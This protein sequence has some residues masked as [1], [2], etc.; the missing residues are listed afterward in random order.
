MQALGPKQI[1]L[2]GALT[3]WLLSRYAFS[4]PGVVLTSH[5]LAAAVVECWAHHLASQGIHNLWLYNLGG[6]AEF[7]TLAV[8]LSIF[9]GQRWRWWILGGG[10]ALYVLVQIIERVK[11][12]SPDEFLNLSAI[13]GAAL[14][15]SASAFLLYKLANDELIALGSRP[16][17]LLFSSMALY[18]GG[19]IPLMGLLGVMTDRNEEL[20]DRIYAINDVLF[21]ASNALIIFA[22]IRFRIRGATLWPMRTL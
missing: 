1:I 11:A 10:L 4:W 16:E 12:T 6:V 7:V 2:L 17:F 8:F 14:L 3:C 19:M 18:Y 5:L 20:T 15:A 21:V 9:F 13:T 22:S